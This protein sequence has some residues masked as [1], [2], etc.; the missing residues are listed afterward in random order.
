M[1]PWNAELGIEIWATA[2]Y[3]LFQDHGG[4]SCIWI[5][6]MNINVKYQHVIRDRSMKYVNTVR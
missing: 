5:E 4:P 2:G 1:G 3:V 6:D